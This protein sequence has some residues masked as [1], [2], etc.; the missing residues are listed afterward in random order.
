MSENAAQWLVVL[1]FVVVFAGVMIAE[2]I[3]LVRSGWTTAGRA[4]VFVLST[5]FFSFGISSIFLMTL[6]LAGF[7]MVMG[8]SGQGGNA[9]DAAYWALLGLMIIVPP[10]VLFLAKR[11][12][13]ALLKIRSGSSAWLYSLVSSLVT[14]IA[15]IVPPALLVYIVWYVAAWRL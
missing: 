10:V 8:P 15:T 14:L 2:T 6:V 3:W 4:A 5:N 7:M 9:P 1:F 13:L 11:S 12:M